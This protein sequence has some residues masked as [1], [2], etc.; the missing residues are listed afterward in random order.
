MKNDNTKEDPAQSFKKS[1][2]ASKNGYFADTGISFVVGEGEE[3]L[4]KLCDVA[5]KAFE[6]GLKKAKPG[7]KKSRIGKSGVRNSETAWIH[8]YQKP[9]RTW[10]WT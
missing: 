2:S 6:A 4:T 10:C 8:G 1:V 3:V 7:S 9:Y 5:K